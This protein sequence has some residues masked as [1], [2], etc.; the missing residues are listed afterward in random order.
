MTP[1]NGRH[2]SLFIF[3]P[4]VN[5]FPQKIFA[6]QVFSALSEHLPLVC[7]EYEEDESEADS[8]DAS[9]TT[10]TLSEAPSRTLRVVLDTDTQALNHLYEYVLHDGTI[11][12]RATGTDEPGEWKSISFD[13]DD[14]KLRPDSLRVD[15]ANLMVRDQ[16]GHVHYKKVLQEWRDSDGAYH[17]NDLNQVQQ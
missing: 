2:D 3:I 5:F 14:G 1:A 13:S 8:S 17:Y 16:N 11:W 15:G 7:S 12:Y 6:P 9:A 10:A 4:I